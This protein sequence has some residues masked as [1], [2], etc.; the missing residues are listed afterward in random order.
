MSNEIL[1]KA[2]QSDLEEIFKYNPEFILEVPSYITENLSHSLRPYQEYALLHFFYTQQAKKYKASNHHLFHMATGSGKTIVL[3]ST[4][5]YLFREKGHQNFIFFVNSDAILKKTLD[6]LTNTSSL[7]YLFNKNGIVIDGQRIN[8]VVTDVFPISKSPNTIYLKLTT[9][10]K[11]HNDLAAPKENRVNFETLKED[12]LILLADEAHH[13]NAATR[14]N[15]KKFTTKELE[16]KTWE[17]TVRDLLELNPSNRLIEFTATINLDNS[18]LFEKYKDK[19]VYQYDL[20]QF[21]EDGFSKKVV[22]LRSNEEDDQKMMSALLLS[23][24]KKYVAEDYGVKLKPVILF[25]SNKI[26]ISI[27]ANSKF[28]TLIDNLTPSKLKNIVERGLLINSSRQ[29]TLGKMYHYYADKD[30]EKIVKDIKWDFSRGNIMNAN[31]TSFLSEDNALLLNTLENFNNPIRAIFAVAKLNE[32]WD[33]LNLFDIVRISEGSTQTRTVTDSE[34]Q[35][36]GRGARYYPFKLDQKKS[37]IRR[38]DYS[39]TDLKMIETLHYHTINE[40]AYINNLYKSLEAANIQSEEDEYERREAKIKPAIRKSN[41]YKNGKVYVNKVI[42]TDLNDYQSF[43]DYGVTTNYDMDYEV[44]IE[45]DY[46]ASSVQNASVRKV[47]RKFKVDPVILRKAMQRN[48]FYHF[49]NLKQYLPAANS[50]YDIIHDKRFFGDLQ[51]NISLPSKLEIN[52]LTPQEKLKIVDR[53]LKYASDKI[54]LNFMKQKGTSQF[55]AVPINQIFTDYVIEV[56][57]T[58]NKRIND[59]VEPYDMKNFPFYIYDQANVNKTEKKLIDFVNDYLEELSQQYTEV[60]LIRNERK[61]KLV[62]IGGVEGFQP[63]FILYLKDKEEVLYQ[64]FI[65]PKGDHLK[66]HDLWKQEFLLSL[67]SSEIEV[68]S[69]NED[70]RIM[71]LKFFSETMNLNQAFRQDFNKKILNVTDTKDRKIKETIKFLREKDAFPLYEYSSLN[72]SLVEKRIVDFVNGHLEELS[73]QY[74]EFYLISNEN[75]LKFPKGGNEL[76]FQPDFIVYLKNK[77]E[78]EALYQVFLVPKNNHEEGGSFFNQSTLFSLDQSK[79]EIL[80]E[81]EDMQLSG[82]KLST[83]MIN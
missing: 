69:E 58:K 22:L 3:A 66:E 68:L 37:Y 49:S 20:R 9:I 38:Y 43:E 15:K 83:D 24:Y 48:A 7:K 13:I 36:I 29:S 17:N 60:Y 4:I 31:D 75:N 77:N 1:H 21:M 65:E 25:K 45:Q 46:L 73:K 47:Y 64:V 61:L 67:D 30:F 18:L 27:E 52:S 72:D 19:I 32:G 14:N 12:S 74:K 55:E 2:L 34:A 63:D 80:F 33:V 42:S 41:F 62:K 59:V 78:E 82:F 5:L 79:A 8:V 11:L 71:G 54:K 28:L 51:I 53:Y 76:G 70:V 10:Q 39:D 44:G 16:E 57:K 23:Q 81:N 56:A 40:N 50:L 26:A 35:L 6:N